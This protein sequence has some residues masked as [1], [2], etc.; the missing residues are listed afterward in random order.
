M[1]PLTAYMNL[2]TATLEL[3][4]EAIK[5]ASPEQKRQMLQWWIDDVSWWRAVLKIE[6]K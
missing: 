1:D 2:A 5:D 3:L 4:K 6:R